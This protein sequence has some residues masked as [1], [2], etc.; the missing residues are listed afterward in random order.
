[1]LGNDLPSYRVLYRCYVASL[2]RRVLGL[3]TEFLEFFTVCLD[4]DINVAESNV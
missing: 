3:E 2:L 1:M 4:P